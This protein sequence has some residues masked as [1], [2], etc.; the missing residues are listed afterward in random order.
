MLNKL[1]IQDLDL[2]G[3]R[4]L[5]RVDFNVPLES[6]KI[7]D[8][9]RIRAALPT[10]KQV[11]SHNGKAILVSHLGRPKGFDPKFSLKPVSECLSQLL[12]VEVRQAPDCIGPEVE[13]LVNSMKPGELLFL[14]NVRFY[15][16]EEKNDPIFA[17]KLASLAEVYVNDAFGA[18]H[19]AHASIVGVTKYLPLS[20]AGFLIQNEI[21]YL[22]K[23]MEKPERPFIAILGGVKVSDKIEVIKN[24]LRKADA[25][26]IGGAM[27]Y[28][29][30]KAQGR[31]VGDSL[32]EDEMLPLAKEILKESIDLSLPLYLPICHVIADRFAPDANI[33]YVKR[34]AIPKGW[35]AL[36]IGPDTV[37]K[38][39]NVIK[40][41]RTIFWN[42]PLGV[43]EFEAFAKGTIA[44]AKLLAESTGSGATTII[45]GGDCVAA[46][47]KAGV[48][49]K[50]T[51]ISTGGGASLE[52][53][54]GKELPGIAALTDK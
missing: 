14:E 50:I 19:R 5:T 12:G 53:L 18:S 11:V 37:E 29:F 8:D 31:S 26:I 47:Q 1:G 13:K 16:E 15:A 46:V 2:N 17:Q 7:L 45:G 52:F 32:V 23:S 33:N 9:T 3:K 22:H 49:D 39:A 27:A 28:T 42:G 20:A 48:A 30:L 38:F 51:H 25:I 44:I 36:D 4:V 35:Q 34:G 43:Y 21:K 24:L 10:I 6:G 40:T 54:E 41:A